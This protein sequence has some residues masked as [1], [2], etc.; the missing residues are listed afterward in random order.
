MAI[1]NIRIKKIKPNAIIPTYKTDS[2][3]GMDLCACIDEPISLKPLER[4][5]VPTGIAIELPHGFEAQ[6]RARS[7]LSIKNGITMVNGVG[8][9]DADYRG[10]IGVLVVNLGK[11][12][13]VIEPDM[14]IAQLVV[15][16]YEKVIWQESSI[17]NE[18]ER[19]S[20][21]FGSTGE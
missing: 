10:E 13:F 6:V 19:G 11:E 9:I 21:G 3:A 2:S 20:G 16:Q 1:L 8:T 14:R 18:T 17:L 15:A 12:D 7:G 4:L 5:M